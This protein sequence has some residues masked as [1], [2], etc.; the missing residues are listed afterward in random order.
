MEG[1]KKK[2]AASTAARKRKGKEGNS[3]SHHV[4]LEESAS[5]VMNC[6]G[7]RIHLARGMSS[8]TCMRKQGA[9]EDLW[10]PGDNY[11]AIH[12]LSNE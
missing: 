9:K 1:E 6:C 8:L 5:E 10:S 3:P 7:K 2:K 12:L 11:R 4:L